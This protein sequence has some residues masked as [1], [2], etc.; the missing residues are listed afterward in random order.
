MRRRWWIVGL[1]AVALSAAPVTAGAQ[2]DEPTEE[3]TEQGAEAEDDEGEEV[4]AF[5]SRIRGEFGFL[6]PLWHQIQF[7]RGNTYFDFIEDGGQ[8]VLFPFQRVAVEFEFV[9]RHQMV[10]LYQP[11]RLESRVT[12]AER[13]AIE[14]TVFPAGTPV[15]IVYGFPFFRAS[16]LYDFAPAEERELAAGASL[17]VRN[18]TIVFSSADGTLREANRDLG[19]VPILKFRARVPGPGKYWYGAEVDG[20]YAPIGY[21]NGDA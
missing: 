11:L 6:A 20:F 18:A 10:L 14:D 2:E 5:S 19:L 4:E 1:L 7:G 16:Y 21:L 12:L 3:E 17:Q 8:D 13:V 15:D 9:E